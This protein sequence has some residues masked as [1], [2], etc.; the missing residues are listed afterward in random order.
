MCV[1]HEERI[2]DSSRLGTEIR[3]TITEATI[4]TPYTGILCVHTL[5]TTENI[6]IDESHYT[7]PHC[8]EFIPLGSR[9]VVYGESILTGGE[10]NTNFN[11]DKTEV[12]D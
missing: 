12:F 2:V 1:Y 8:W 3:G 6:D 9:A 11:T 5:N 7:T 4:Q 10:W